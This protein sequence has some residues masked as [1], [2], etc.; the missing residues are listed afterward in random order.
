MSSF[1][2]CGCEKLGHVSGAETIADLFGGAITQFLSGGTTIFGSI[3][4]LLKEQ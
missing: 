1:F 3:T 4:E 2:P